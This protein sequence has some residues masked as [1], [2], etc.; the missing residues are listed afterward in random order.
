MDLTPDLGPF[1][2]MA[3]FLSALV[4]SLYFTPLIRKGAI[5]YGVVDRPDGR[6][7][8]H[9][10][11]TPYLGG[12][13]VYLAF[14]G[15]LAFTY[16]FT[17]EVL[18]LLLAASIVVMLGLFDDLK[19]LTPGVKLV[20]QAVAAL[21][22]IKA[23]VMIRLAFLPEWLALGLTL[24]WLVGVTNALNLI[25][26]SDG[27][28]AGC[29]SIA[30]LFLCAVSLYN[31]HTTIAMLTLALVGSA[32]GFLA[33]N[34]P[35]ARI[36]LGDTGSMFLGFMLGALAMSGHYTFRHK[37][38]AVAPAVILGVPI[39]DT[40][41]VMG[42][43][44]ARGIPLMRGSPDHFAVR[45]RNNGRSAGRIAL[46]GYG[47]SL[48][49]GASALALCLAPEGLALGILAAL[50]AVAGLVVLRLKRLGRGP[51]PGGERGGAQG[52]ASD[53]LV[54]GGAGP[55]AESTPRG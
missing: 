33:Y 40:L 20:G 25:D 43:R 39:F 49:L 31:G 42:V 37:L 24:F 54:A 21:V 19:V 8:Q 32:I 2:Y 3:A 15:S 6:L 12:V 52:S 22:L 29:A 16:E 28:A 7:K 1:R 4:L 47:A 18:G 9:R 35:P 48:V 10:A 5:A 13:A 46:W 23:G 17:A 41:Y 55:G 50:A 53:A 44:A 26:V 51:I 11:P 14:L 34:R 45:L 38:A 27:L 36:F 30:G